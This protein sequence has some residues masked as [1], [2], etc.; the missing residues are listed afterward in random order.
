M[1]SQPPP[2][3][4]GTA[5]T[6]MALLASRRVRVAAAVALTLLVAAIARM[7]PALPPPLVPQR[8]IEAPATAPASPADLAPGITTGAPDY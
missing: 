1:S 3:L 8:A 5:D 2:P 4:R 7:N 6:A